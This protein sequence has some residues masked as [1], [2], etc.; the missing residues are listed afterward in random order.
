MCT[1]KYFI[2]ITCYFK[3]A[4]VIIFIDCITCNTYIVKTNPFIS[5]IA[6]RFGRRLQLICRQ[7]VNLINYN[8]YNDTLDEI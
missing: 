1:S 3:S 2:L 8:K 4:Q 5:C 7:F 6:R